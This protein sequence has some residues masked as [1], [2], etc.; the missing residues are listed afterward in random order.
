M[1]AT[2]RSMAVARRLRRHPAL[3]EWESAAGPST[4]QPQAERSPSPLLR[5]GA[6]P[7]RLLP[8]NADI[9]IRLSQSSVRRGRVPITQER[10]RHERSQLRVFCSGS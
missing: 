10:T 8:T 2:A 1:R 6:V 3:A 7:D 5:N 4:T 9:N